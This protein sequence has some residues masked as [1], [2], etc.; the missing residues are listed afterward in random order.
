MNTA[1]QK[2]SRG[3]SVAVLIPFSRGRAYELWAV[4]SRLEAALLA[5]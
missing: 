1:N 2:S 5:S 4:A 3:A